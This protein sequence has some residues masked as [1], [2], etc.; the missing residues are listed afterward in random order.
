M[1]FEIADS[2]FTPTSGNEVGVTGRISFSISNQTA[3]GYWSVPLQ[4]LLKRG[5]SVIGVS[6]TSVERLDAG[7]TRNIDLS[8]LQPVPTVTEVVVVPVL[9]IF[10]SAGYMP[11]KSDSSGM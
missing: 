5:N 1:R 7:E 10:D 9:N 3:F 6:S 2:K 8:W 11:P 4:V